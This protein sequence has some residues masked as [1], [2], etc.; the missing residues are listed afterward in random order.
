MFCPRCGAENRLAEGYC[1][2]CGEWLPDLDSSAHRRRHGPRT[3]EQKLRVMMMF[4]AINSALALFSSIALYATYLGRKDA[5][6]SVHVAAAC[7]LVI[8]IHQ[9]LSFVFNLQ[10]Q[11]RLKKA[12][13][14]RGVE[15][16]MLAATQQ[17]APELQAADTSQFVTAAR[18]QSV[19]EG[20][21][22]LLEAVPRRMN[23]TGER[24]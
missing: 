8:A 24:R 6:W 2:H 23:E 22:E 14:T 21:T 5:Q 15:S 12:R 10:I 18:G 3:P 9:M 13:T 7:C 16:N 19:T 20:T 4:S 11:R 1:T 17:R